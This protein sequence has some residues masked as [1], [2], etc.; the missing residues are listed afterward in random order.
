MARMKQVPPPD[1]SFTFER[2]RPDQTWIE[3]RGIP[4]PGGGFV[5]TYVDTTDRRRAEEAQA[6]QL[7]LLDQIMRKIDQGIVVIDAEDRMVG[8]NQRYSELLDLP[9][10]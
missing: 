2:K 4:L 10:E 6:E 1:K 8:F 9:E 7:E 3:V 5:R